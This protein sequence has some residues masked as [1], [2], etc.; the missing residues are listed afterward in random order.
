MAKKSAIRNRLPSATHLRKQLKDA[1][2]TLFLIGAY[3]LLIVVTGSVAAVIGLH[4]KSASHSGDSEHDTPFSIVQIK[5]VPFALYYP[6]DLPEPLHIDHDSIS[7]AD[8]AIVTMRIT[9]GSGS[10]TNRSLT[11]SEQALPASFSMDAFNQGLENKT[12]FKQSYGTATV[13][14]VNYGQNKLAVIQTNDKTLVVIQA[15]AGMTAEDL[16]HIVQNFVLA[17]SE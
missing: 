6:T 13:G 9:D 17:K 5:S 12:S 16:S 8:T 3:I 4:Q 7:F 10:L 15:D 1:P 2:L 14:T 11:I